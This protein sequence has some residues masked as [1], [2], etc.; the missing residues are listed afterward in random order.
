METDNNIVLI[1]KK[2]KQQNLIDY[3]KV[4]I[5]DFSEYKKI[6]SVLRSNT[7][8]TIEIYDVTQNPNKTKILSVNDHIN[9]IGYNPFIGNQDK[10]K[11]D[12]IN[13]EKLYIQKENGVVTDSCGENRPTGDYPSSHL[14]N[15]AIMCHIF[16]Y[17]V[18]AYLVNQ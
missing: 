5:L 6:E 2:I 8:Q 7:P 9:R 3:K 12:F 14:A 17:K 16:N 13:I 1:N 15:I 11:I 18:E 10:F 4:Y